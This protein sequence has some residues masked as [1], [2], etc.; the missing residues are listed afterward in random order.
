M[1]PHVWAKI[2]AP[3]QVAGYAPIELDVAAWMIG[4][5]ASPYG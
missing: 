5:K 2:E 1:P 3:F 4:V